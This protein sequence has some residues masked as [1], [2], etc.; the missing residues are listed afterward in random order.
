[1]EILKPAQK[2]SAD[3]E[4]KIQ[5][6][7]KEIEALQKSGVSSKEAIDEKIAKEYLPLAQ[8]LQGQSQQLRSFGDSEL[9]KIHSTI[10]PKIQKAADAVVKSQGW[11][12]A[13]NREAVIST[14]S[15]GSRFNI[16]SDVLE[17]LNK[18]YVQDKAKEAADKAKAEAK[19]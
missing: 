4:A 13:I 11:D 2:E 19:K 6:K 15:S 7:R 18:Q 12:F 5:E 17:I 3:L 16:T 10:L 8:Q 14:I 1:M 9:M